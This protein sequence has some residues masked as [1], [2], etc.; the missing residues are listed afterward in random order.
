MLASYPPQDANRGDD[1]PDIDTI[2]HF[3]E[4][5]DITPLKYQVELEKQLKIQLDQALKGI[6]ASLDT[7][8]YS[9][10]LCLKVEARQQDEGKK[11][12]TLA[13]IPEQSEY[14]VLLGSPQLVSDPTKTFDY[15]LSFDGLDDCCELKNLSLQLPHKSLA[16]SLWFKK[17]PQSSTAKYDRA[18]TLLSQAL[19]V[20]QTTEKFQPLYLCLREDNRLCIVQG[21]NKRF[22]PNPLLSDRWHHLT[23]S[24]EP[25]ETTYQITIYIDGKRQIQFKTDCGVVQS[26]QV[27]CLNPISGLH[28]FKG[29]IAQVCL[30]NRVLSAVEVAR[31]NNRLP[32][33][34]Y[35]LQQTL[36]QRYWQPNEPVILMT[37]DDIKPTQ[38]YGQDGRYRADRTLACTIVSE[39]SSSLKALLNQHHI[40]AVA[41]TLIWVSEFSQTLAETLAKTTS[42]AI[43]L[44]TWNGQPWNPILMEWEVQMQPAQTKTDVT[45]GGYVHN[46]I[47]ENYILVDGEIDLE[48]KQNKRNIGVGKSYSNACILTSQPGNQF[49]GKIKAYLDKN[50]FDRATEYEK[51][52]PEEPYRL[53][54]QVWYSQKPSKV[55]NVDELIDI[56]DTKEW[57]LT[58]PLPVPQSTHQNDQLTNF[59]C[60]GQDQEQQRQDPV[61]I[62]ILAYEIL[63]PDSKPKYFLSQSLSGF[64][65]ELLMFKQTLQLPVSDPLSFDNYQQLTKKV[66]ML[67]GNILCTAPEP[68]N[69]FSPVRSGAMKIT[70]LR[71]VD[72][73]GQ[74]KEFNEEVAINQGR[75]V[76]TPQHLAVPHSPHL[77]WLPPRLVQPARLDFQW[78]LADEQD[79]N[80]TPICG[81][82]LPDILNRRLAVYDAQGKALGTIAMQKNQI[83]WESAPCSNRTVDE[84]DAHLSQ[85]IQHI[86]SRSKPEQTII[87]GDNDPPN[88]LENLIIAI[89]SA[90][91][92][93]DPKNSAQDQSLALLI[94]R[95]LAIVRA[96]LNIEL[97]GE[98]AV[99]QSW[100][101]FRLALNRTIREADNFT[102]VQF[103]IRVGDYNRF[104]DGIICY[105]KEA[106]AGYEM[107]KVFLPKPSP[108][109]K[110]QHPDI[111]SRNHQWILK[112]QFLENFQDS[113]AIQIW[114]QLLEKRWLLSLN[115]DDSIARVELKDRLPLD[116]GF[117]HKEPQI[118]EILS[119]HVIN[120]LHIVQSI[121]SPPQA[122]TMLIDPR[123]LIHATSGILPTKVIHLAPQDY[124]PALEAIEITFLNAP[125]LSPQG[126]RSL[127]L[128]IEPGFTWS[129]LEH[130]SKISKSVFLDILQNQENSLSLE[131]A[132]ILWEHL[133]DPKTG[134]LKALYETKT[135]AQIMPM[136]RRSS[137]VIS[138]KIASQ[139]KQDRSQLED[140][141]EQLFWADISATPIIRKSLLMQ[142]LFDRLNPASSLEVFTQIT[143]QNLWNYLVDPDVTWLKL[144]AGNP[145]EAEVVPK[146]NRVTQVLSF[147]PFVLNR[148][149]TN[150]AGIVKVF[151]VNNCASDLDKTELMQHLFKEFQPIT[152]FSEF[153][154][155]TG[156]QIWEHLSSSE[157]GWLKL[158]DDNPEKAEVLQISNQNISNFEA[159]SFKILVGLPGNTT[160]I[161]ESIF[162]LEKLSLIPS[163]A[164]AGFGKS[165]ELREGWLVLS[166][167]H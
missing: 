167:A 100:H 121:D 150:L 111:V 13:V 164:Q 44:Q 51:L 31:E 161:L 39:E 139:I 151:L 17:A 86:L 127:P 66:N 57:Y 131:D 79:P 40:D 32:R 149:M 98:P 36:D 133:L 136:R 152:S 47:T 94:G 62:A 30:D 82:I 7:Y 78:L 42:A 81:W 72:T 29:Y 119:E 70:R 155:T 122:I 97:Q 56:T 126:T 90:L 54:L 134:W 19:V 43:A 158:H 87:F 138:P 110:I 146:E 135:T 116:K 147:R 18:Q 166:K 80:A 16:L 112:K 71:L 102:R 37:G 15:C 59:L 5:R 3:I 65:A 50:L 25:V 75:G 137:E 106:V 83:Q 109:S 20:L 105:W 61:Y 163:T 4:T 115:H 58:K 103:P 128:S 143:G 108:Y 125:I 45:G 99:N 142:R 144:L 91:S 11:L 92:C 8:N 77:I 34:P 124:I 12:P 96:S 93:I 2:C 85:L 60:L 35:L 55:S 22:A 74:V 165:Q 117:Q 162:E 73:F 9:T 88:Y 132:G 114:A 33:I 53:A 145:T 63:C 118:E 76:L 120:P 157:V 14:Y 148:E 159:K 49:I 156:Q 107:D 26:I 140:Q 123:G 160:E 113:Q 84:L 68:L 64:N 24:C 52:N 104:N 154:Q 10:V 153:T 48:I 21:E 141:I 28:P 6:Q 101:S 95:P 23:L 46:V 67:L 89:E 130:K 69:Q 129:W 38:R 27:S 41:D 1:Y